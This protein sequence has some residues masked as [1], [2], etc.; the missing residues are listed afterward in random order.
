M[1]SRR[2][3]CSSRKGLSS[4]TICTNVLL[5]RRV[6]R[7]LIWDF[8]L[9]AGAMARRALYAKQALAMQFKEGII[10]A[11]PKP[12]FDHASSFSFTPSLSFFIVACK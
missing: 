3:Q 5:G 8:L 9:G 12:Q 4:D 10:N 1:Q 11:R 6:F 2:W 7:R